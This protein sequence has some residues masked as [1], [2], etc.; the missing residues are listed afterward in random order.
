VVI[1]LAGRAVGE[2][3]PCLVVAEAGVNHNGDVE[4]AERLVDAAAAACAD[5]VKFQSFRAEAVA[6]AGAPKAAYQRAAT[7]EEESQQEMLRALE[8]S[9]ETHRRLQRRAQEHGLLFLSTPFDAASADLLEELGVPAFKVASPDLT[10]LPFLEYLAAKGRPLIVSTGMAELSEVEAALAALARVGATDVVLL[11]CVSSYPAPAAEQNL[12]TIPA[13]AARFGVPVGFSDHTTGGAAALA[14]VALGACLL[15]KHFTLDR[16]LP[17]PDHAASLEPAELAGLVR[18][19]REVEA[20]LGDGV[21][22]PTPAERENRELVRRSL[23]AAV[24]LP[25]G[26]LLERSMLTALRPGTGIAPSRIDE[27]VG[28]RLRRSVA[29]GELLDPAAVE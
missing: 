18:D 9:A 29:G 23:A 25:A 12:R 7:G 27:V 17:G 2:G 28:R 21:K 1:D 24:D 8:L 6:S 22:R 4:L 26:T 16:T 11:Q 14:A 20:A 19:V 10:N 3:A 15:E 5:A 13:L